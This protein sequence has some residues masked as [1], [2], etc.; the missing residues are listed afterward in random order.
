M[1]IKLRWQDALL[2]FLLGLIYF[3]LPNR[4]PGNDA[5]AYAAS[6]RWGQELFS[7]HHLLYNLPGRLWSLLTGGWRVIEFMQALNA[8]TTAIILLLMSRFFPLGTK[9]ILRKYLA[10][11]LAGSCFVVF[12]YATENEAYMIPAAL[13]F[14]AFF[15][16]RN[17]KTLLISGLLLALSFLFHQQHIVSLGAAFVYLVFVEKKSF[18]ELFLFLTPSIVLIPL[19]YGIAWTQE[20]LL[21]NPFQYFFH[22]FYKGSATWVAGS[23]HWV[24][25]PVN[26]IRIFLYV[27]GDII[28]IVANGTSQGLIGILGG[29]IFFG[30]IGFLIIKFLKSVRAKSESNS[31]RGVSFYFRREDNKWLNL[32]WFGFLGHFVFSMWF[33]AN[34]EFMVPLP[35]VGVVLLINLIGESYKPVLL[36]CSS[37]LLIWNISFSGI[38]QRF[39]ILDPSQHLAQL[40]Q[41][42]PQ[43]IWILYDESRV[44]HVLNY[45]AG[46]QAINLL[47]GPEWYLE[48]GRKDSELAEII[49][50][51]HLQNIQV[52]SDCPYRPRPFNR[53]SFTRA[54]DTDFWNAFEVQPIL[55]IE[56]LGHSYPISQIL[57]PRAQCYRN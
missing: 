25:A 30:S 45:Y 27:H 26:L 47:H 13:M 49:R 42:Y 28:A 56:T 20:P 40:I 43:A 6:A 5:W 53:A 52:Y 14:Y 34:H 21:E 48:T 16:M 8:L 38:S 1:M 18:K 33:G 22:D 39:Q 37:G 57:P 32:F 55:N 9:G 7:P 23:K 36:W 50:E 24:L 41:E 31:F 2:P 46:K 15:L 35:F 29:I 17:G 4:N 44:R 3:I 19:V 51:A 54:E 11:L 12:H 10:Q